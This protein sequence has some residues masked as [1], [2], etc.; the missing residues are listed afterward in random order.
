MW[1]G[2][3]NS[4]SPSTVDQQNV[5]IAGTPI[6]IL[7]SPEDNAIAHILAYIQSAQTSIHFMAFTFTHDELGAAMLARA[8]AGVEVSGVFET[9]G[10]D[11]Q[12]SEMIPL[13]C[14]Q[15]PVRQD[16]NPQFMHHKVIIID[17]EIVV[18]G[19]LNFTANADEANNE[20]VVILKNKDIAALYLQEFNRI[21]SLG[22]DPD[23]NKITCK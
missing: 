19:S 14:A 7:F 15:F 3:F 23:P 4:R 22:R 5:T 9:V 10:S 12:Y 11:A 8:S 21:W 2:N 13:F 17:N 18:T 20:N 1:N 6:Q 16:G